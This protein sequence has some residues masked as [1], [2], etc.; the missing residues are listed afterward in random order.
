MLL[1]LAGVTACFQFFPVVRRKSRNKA[2]AQ[3]QIDEEKWADK[4]TQLADLAN[5]EL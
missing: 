5:A 3:L 2:L 4:R 1:P